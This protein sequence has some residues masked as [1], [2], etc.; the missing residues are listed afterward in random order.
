ML[1]SVI[2]ITTSLTPAE[3]VEGWFDYLVERG[4]TRAITKALRKSH[5]IL[6]RL[7]K[8]GEPIP[9]QIL[10]PDLPL[11]KQPHNGWYPKAK[12]NGKRIVKESGGFS[13]RLGL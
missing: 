7:P 12:M 10:D 4:H 11:S 5:G 6:Y 3:E 1:D 13:R 8:E 9:K 2:Q